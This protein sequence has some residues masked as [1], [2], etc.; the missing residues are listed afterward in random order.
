MG[1][2]RQTMGMDD[3]RYLWKYVESEELGDVLKDFM[4]MSEKRRFVELQ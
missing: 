1:T 3:E 2:D 4:H